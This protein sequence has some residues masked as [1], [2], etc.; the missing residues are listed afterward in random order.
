MSTTGFLTMLDIAKAN[1]SDAVAGLISEVHLAHPEVSGM[2]LQNVGGKVERVKLGNVAFSRTINGVS[3]KTLVL[4]TLP[5]VSFRNANEGGNS[6]NAEYENRLVETFILNPFWKTDKAVA[7][8]HEDGREAAIA[9]MAK[10]AMMAAMRTLGYQFYYGAATNGDLKGH[11]GLIGSVQHVVDAGGTTDN[12][13]SSVWA[14]KFGPQDVAWVYGNKG[15]MDLSEVTERDATD[16]SNKTFTAYHQELTVYP[17]LQVGS[18]QC[19]GRIKKLTTDANKGLTDALIADLLAKL[20][21]GIVPDV[22][23]M[24]RRSRTQLQ[25][26]RTATTV[27]G[28]QAP[29]P[30]DYEGIPIAVTD[31]ILDTETLAL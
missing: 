11:P 28:V 27:T 3:Y 12:V 14:V 20:P 29:T 13:A 17:G 16:A 2:T 18:T 30:T 23:F 5:T 24:T 9:L 10:P 25:K 8:R 7:D 31:S 21:A 15:A 1:G 22:L 4:K 6:V 19:I 26:S